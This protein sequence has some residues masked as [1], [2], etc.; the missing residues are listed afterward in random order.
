MRATYRCGRTGSARHNDR[1]FDLTN[2]SHI[3]QRRTD[4][5]YNWHLFKHK[6]PNKTFSEVEEIFYTKQYSASLEATNSRYRAQYHPERCKTIKDLLKS[7][8]TR[9]EEVILQIGNM[10]DYPSPEVLMECM[11]EFTNQMARWNVQH[12]NHLHILNF[13]IHLDEQTPH[14]HLR[15]C[16]DYIDKDGHPRLGQEKALEAAGVELPDPTRKAGRYNNRKMT[17]D[18]MMRAKWY[19]ILKSHGLEIETEPLPRR[20]HMIKEKFID[21]QIAKKSEKVVELEEQ[22]EK[23]EKQV[24]WTK[25]LRDKQQ[26]L[27]EK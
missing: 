27:K 21:S 12:G 18:N 7:P 17:F 23:L 14:V 4:D 11:I 3:D 8:Q 13:S 20:K 5:N 9:P 22:L 16:W 6:L 15:R 1:D 24:D 2:S 10:D 26:E 25:D 19:E